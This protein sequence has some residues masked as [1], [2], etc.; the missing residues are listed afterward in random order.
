[1]VKKFLNVLHGHIDAVPPIWLMRQA[2]RYL[3]EYKAVRAQAGEFLDLVYNP[4]LATEVTLQPLRRY[5]FDA[6]IL[7]SDIL[8]VPQ[9]LGQAVSFAANHGPV[10]GQL[11]DHLNFREAAFQEFM[12]PV[13]ET[14]SRIRTGMEQEGFTDTALIGFSGAP[15]T[16]ACYM[17]EQKGSRDFQQ[18]RLYAL[19]QPEKFA[20]LMNVLVE[21]VAAYLI[22][23]VRAGAEAI[24]IF[25]SWAGVVPETQ[26]ENWVIGPTAR[27]V[28]ELKAVCPG[29]PVIG[30]PKGIGA[31]LP[32]YVAV[33]AVDAVSLDAQTP[34][35]WAASVL[36]P[37]VTI[38]GNM[39]P[40]ALIAG[41]SELD[42]QVDHILEVMK[43]RRHIFNLGHGIDKDTPPEHVAQL[44][45]RIRGA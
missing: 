4:E 16:L 35:E 15:W 5:G 7:F 39:D 43:G 25:D 32:A 3:P 40:L 9:A 27:I 28:K 10:L 11:P 22:K 37:H 17:I 6:A 31:N 21:A 23:Q 26:L 19:R 42:L 41:G 34:L 18:T 29:I 44:V 36:P 1:M 33:T 13:Y 14:V 20:A 24:Q 38:Q 45:N 8:T 30:F 12:T 2:G